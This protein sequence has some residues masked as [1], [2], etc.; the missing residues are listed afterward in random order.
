MTH[1]AQIG[2]PSTTY[3]WFVHLVPTDTDCLI[4]GLHHHG[5]PGSGRARV[6]GGAAKLLFPSPLL[7]TMYPPGILCKP[8][9]DVQVTQGHQHVVS[10][11]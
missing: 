1:R 5:H 9:L 11:W 6:V 4:N 2:G 3:I 10:A 8:S 7:K